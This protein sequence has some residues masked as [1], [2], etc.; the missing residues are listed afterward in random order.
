MLVEGERGGFASASGQ[1]TRSRGLVVTVPAD[2][3]H[4]RVHPLTESTGGVRLRRTRPERSADGDQCRRLALR[5]DAATR[6]RTGVRS[7]PR[8]LAGGERT[9]T[10]LDPRTASFSAR[11]FELDAESRRM[12]V[13]RDG[14]RDCGVLSQQGRRDSNPRPTVLETAALPTELRPCA[15]WPVPSGFR[16]FRS[17]TAVRSTRAAPRAR[18]PFAVLAAALAAVAAYAFAGGGDARRLV[19]GLAAVA[20]AAWLATLSASAFRRRRR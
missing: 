5:S 15:G 20:V 7:P 19:I 4:K 11:L 1:P 8:L 3:G 6:T 13:D 9:T 10:R 2:V 18:G 17:S 14:L 12:P 16:C